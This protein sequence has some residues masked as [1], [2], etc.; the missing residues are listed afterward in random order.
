VTYR[1][2]SDEELANPRFMRDLAP[3]EWRGYLEE[4][5]RRANRLAEAALNAWKIY[6]MP[7]RAGRLLDEALRSYLG[8][9]ET[10]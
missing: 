8:E 1:P 6:P 2:L 10:P 9:E 3:D 5:C 7:G 4:Q